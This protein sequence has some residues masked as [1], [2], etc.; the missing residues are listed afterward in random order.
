MLLRDR[1]QN[2]TKK[3]K[4]THCREASGKQTRQ[5]SKKLFYQVPDIETIDMVLE[6]G[7]AYTI[8]TD[9]GSSIDGLEEGEDFGMF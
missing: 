9:D 6:N 4:Q 5:M 3:T 8:R 7:I 2:W 1:Q